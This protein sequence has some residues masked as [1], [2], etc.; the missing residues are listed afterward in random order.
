[1]H[2]GS[3]FDGPGLDLNW[4]P[5]INVSYRLS[6]IIFWIFKTIF[7][8]YA[9]TRDTNIVQSTERVSERNC[10]A[11]SIQRPSICLIY[12][13]CVF[14]TT[15]SSSS[16][17]ATWVTKK[18]KILKTINFLNLIIV[19]Y[20]LLTQSYLLSGNRNFANKV[21]VVFLRFIVLRNTYLFT[22]ILWSP[23]FLR[24]LI[25]NLPHC[26]FWSLITS[27]R[28]LQCPLLLLFLFKYVMRSSNFESLSQ[29]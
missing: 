2:V 24:I 1:M 3:R 9:H 28:N 21:N 25:S 22:A 7:I 5:N 11:L 8:K 23:L 18:V 26:T 12:A 6:I 15:I 14:N 17:D 29:Y 13:N 4:P 19:V 20:K 27:R 16:S 10:S